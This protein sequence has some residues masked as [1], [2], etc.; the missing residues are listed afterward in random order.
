MNLI[1]KV[2]CMRIAMYI[3]MHEAMK[4][5]EKNGKGGDEGYELISP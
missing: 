2:L 3:C 1:T 5:A 4:R